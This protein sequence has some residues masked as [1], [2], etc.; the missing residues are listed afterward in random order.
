MGLAPYQNADTQAGPGSE[1]AHVFGAKVRARD[2]DYELPYLLTPC[3]HTE[4]HA[5]APE[6]PHTNIT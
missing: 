1:V 3:S 5:H 6:H 4:T 2:T